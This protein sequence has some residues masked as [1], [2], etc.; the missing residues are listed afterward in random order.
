MDLLTRRDWENQLNDDDSIPAFIEIKNFLKQRTKAL[1]ATE[2]LRSSKKN[3]QPLVPS[4]STQSGC[5]SSIQETSSS[6]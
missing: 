1:K 4:S 3:H 5:I 6:S 2:A